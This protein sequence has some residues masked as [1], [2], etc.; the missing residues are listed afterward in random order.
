MRKIVTIHN[1]L[2]KSIKKIAE[3]EYRNP[4]LQI[5]FILKDW[6][7]ARTFLM[8]AKENDVQKETG[9]ELLKDI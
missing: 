5:E 8:S 9:F 4:I 2:F 1:E 3:E 7:E 6:L